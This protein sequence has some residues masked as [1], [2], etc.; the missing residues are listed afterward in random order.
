MDNRTFFKKVREENKMSLADIFSDIRRKHTKEETDRVFIAGTELTTPSEAEMLAGWT[1]P[2]LFFKFFLICLIGFLV[3]YVVSLLAGSTYYL[4][5]V[6]IP[7]MIP[8][9]FL[10]LIWEMHIPRNIS[11]VEVVW[12]TAVGGVLSICATLM[13]Q[14]V[15]F[16]LPDAVFAGLLEEPAKLLLIYYFLK[17]KN[18]RYAHW[19]VLW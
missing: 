17:K 2:F 10:L 6:G 3:L 15:G 13:L 16:V 18:Y 4:L 7:F 11:L 19:M 12:M 14:V 8:I 9:T 1:K 5:I